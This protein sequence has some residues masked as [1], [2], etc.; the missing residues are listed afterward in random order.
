MTTFAFLKQNLASF[1]I[2]EKFEDID[3]IGG[4]KY[5]KKV[6][7]MFDYR[8]QYIVNSYR[9]EII[10]LKENNPRIFINV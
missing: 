8:N 5:T 1:I 6:A 9:K 3:Q 7:V 10:D 2:D 4:K